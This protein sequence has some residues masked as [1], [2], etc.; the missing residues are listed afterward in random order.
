MTA[1]NSSY[2]DEL[3]Q[4]FNFPVPKL[5][6][7]QWG[8]SVTVILRLHKEL[9][10]HSRISVGVGCTTEVGCSACNGKTTVLLL[11]DAQLLLNKHQQIWGGVASLSTV[12]FQAV[13]IRVLT[14]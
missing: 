10:Y 6:Q 8:L 11:H 13:P 7:A 5:S 3:K 9:A 2:R 12:I 1:E 4:K 14:L